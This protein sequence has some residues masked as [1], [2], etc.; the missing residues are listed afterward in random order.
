MKIKF[1]K[2]FNG[3]AVWLSFKENKISRN[4]LI[5]GGMS[6]S[7]VGKDKKTGKQTNGDLYD[8]ID[9]IRGQIRRLT[10]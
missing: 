10:C 6:A 2:A 1:L 8:A 9:E 3:D 5:D 4:I 7:F